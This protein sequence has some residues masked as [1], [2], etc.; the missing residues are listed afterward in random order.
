MS[1]VETTLGP[2]PHHETLGGERYDNV[3]NLTR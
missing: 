1:T 2:T 3:I